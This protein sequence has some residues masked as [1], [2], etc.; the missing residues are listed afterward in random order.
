MKKNT[1]TKYTAA[2]ILIISTFLSCVKDQDFST[3][4]VVCTEPNLTVTNT[5]A[6]VKE[7]YTFGGATVIE[8]DVII[9]N[10]GSIYVHT[11]LMN[12]IF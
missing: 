9:G 3:P 12:I 7:M 1:L 10:N 2:F 8:N 11:F 5:I 6:Q 4:N